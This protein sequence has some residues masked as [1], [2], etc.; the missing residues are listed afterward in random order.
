MPLFVDACDG[1][2]VV[3]DLLLPRAKAGR[4]ARRGRTRVYEQS[5]FPCCVTH[6]VEQPKLAGWPG[7]REAFL[8]GLGLLAG[9]RPGRAL[10]RWALNTRPR[11]SPCVVPY[12]PWCSSCDW[13][14]E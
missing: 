9:A 11:A 8:L 1:E 7:G 6:A 13:S 2:N 3:R 10:L 12:F 14:M 4:S 5:R